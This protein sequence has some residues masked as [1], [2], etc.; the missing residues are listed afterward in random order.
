MYEAKRSGSGHAVFDAAQETQLRSVSRCSSICV[1][2]SPATS[3]S[4]TTS[5]RSTWRLARISGVEALIRWR[6]PSMAC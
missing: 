5:P 1:I 2:A 3:W 6:H 4:C